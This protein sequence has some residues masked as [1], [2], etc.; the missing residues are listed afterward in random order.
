MKPALPERMPGVWCWRRFART[1]TTTEPGPGLGVG[2]DRGT[3]GPFFVSWRRAFIVGGR[4]VVD[5]FGYEGLF[6]S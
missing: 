5:I 2:T 3:R 6:P 4:V 1:F